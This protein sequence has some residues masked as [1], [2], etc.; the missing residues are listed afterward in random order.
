VISLR[1]FTRVPLLACP[2][3]LLAL[4]LP[5]PCFSGEE[6]FDA[7][8]FQKHIDALCKTPHRLAG[9]VEGAEARKYIQAQLEE[10]GYKVHTQRFQF[11][12]LQYGEC[13]INVAGKDYEL[14]P[15]RPN[16]LQAAVTPPAGISGKVIYA[17]DG[18]ASEF[19]GVDPRGAIVLLD[20]SQLD[21]GDRAF[22]LGAAA[23]VY[24]EDERMQAFYGSDKHV[25]ITADLPRFFMKREVAERAG[26]LTREKTSATLFASA[27]WKAVE[28]TNLIASIAG[29]GAID[30]EEE[31][32][33][34]S[35]HYDSFGS[36]WGL[37]PGA[38]SAA[39]CAALLETAR[40]LRNTQPLRTVVLAFFDNF[41]QCYLGARTFYYAVQEVRIESGNDDPLQT[42]RREYIQ[43]ERE[44][45]EGLLA[46]LRP[47]LEQKGARNLE[48]L[49]DVAIRELDNTTGWKEDRYF[50]PI[51]RLNRE[52]AK[53]KTPPAEMSAQLEKLRGEK[54]AWNR[55]HR[56]LKDRNVREDQASV[57]DDCC[58]TTEQRLA[59][60]RTE[61]EYLASLNEE[62][63][64]IGE[65]LLSG[66]AGDAER[67]PKRIVAHF[68]F[69]F[70]DLGTQWALVPSS[71][72]GNNTKAFNVF[73]AAIE[74][75]RGSR[76]W[77]NDGFM[78]VTISGLTHPGMWLQTLYADDSDVASGFGY[79]SYAMMTMGDAM[80]REGTPNDSVEKLNAS[81]V[82]KQASEAAALLKLLTDDPDFSVRSPLAAP[83]R[84]YV[85]KR[86]GA[87]FTGNNVILASE[88]SSIS[89]QPAAGAV[90]AAVPAENSS[91]SFSRVMYNP[92]FFAA[93]LQFTDSNGFFPL[94]SVIPSNWA[95]DAARFDARGRV[96]EISTLYD[97][98][99]VIFRGFANSAFKLKL[100]RC[101]GTAL[102]MCRDTLTG[103]PLK[104]ADWK[105]LNAL[106]NAEHTRYY[107]RHVD[108]TVSF[109]VP[110]GRSAKL[111]GRNYVAILNGT[112]KE[113]MGEGFNWT[114]EP[115]NADNALGGH[116][117]PLRVQT[118]LTAAQDLW[119]LNESRLQL[120]RGAGLF[121]NSIERVHGYA[122][123]QLA[124]MRE[125]IEAKKWGS[126]QAHAE[127]ANA[128]SHRV[129]AP[130]IE[131]MN[132]VIRAV[133][134]LLALTVPF[135]FS[136]E[137]LFVG[138]PNIYKQIGGFTAFFVVTFLALYF[139]H[140]AFQLAAT[141]LIIF[142]AF[143][144]IVMS[145][146]VIAIVMGKFKQEITAIQGIS[147]TVHSA[148]VSRMSTTL[149]AV[150]MGISTMRRRPLRTTLTAVTVVL[151]TFTI[152]CFASFSSTSGIIQTYQ[153]NQHNRPCLLVHNVTWSSISPG[154]VQ[155][156]E[157]LLE[158]EAAVYPR[159]WLASEPGQQIQMPLLRADGKR[160]GPREGVMLTGLIA[161]N[162]HEKKIT[163][164]IFAT[165]EG[166]LQQ[167]MDADGVFLS[168]DVLESMELKRGDKVNVG[169]RVFS[170]AG[171]FDEGKVDEIRQVDGSPFLPLDYRA[172]R[173][174]V[175]GGGMND[176][177]ALRSILQS[178]DS[179]SI[180]SI[181][182][183]QVAFMS[184]RNLR[185][186]G[187]RPRGI[188]VVPENADNAVSIARRVAQ[189][190]DNYVF[191]GLPDGV[192]RFHYTARLSFTGVGDLVVPLLLGGLI[193]FSTMLGSVVEREKEIYTFSALGLAPPDVGTLFFAEVCIYAVI[194]GLG[195]YLIGQWLVT[196]L[197]FLSL[198][199]GIVRVPDVNYSST[200]AI[201]TIL[202]VMVTVLL[203]TIYPAIKASRSANPGVQ[204]N[205][206]IPRPAGD[207]HRIIFPFTVSAYDMKGVVSFLKEHF[208]SHNDISLG[209]FSAADATIVKDP[210][211]GMLG[212]DARIWLAPF[213]L[214]I[215]Q[216]FRLTSKPSE[217]PGIHEITIEFER[218]SG[219]PANW[220]R[221]NKVF[222]NELRRQ[223]LIWRALTHDAMEMY[224]ARTEAALQSQAEGPVLVQGEKVA[225]APN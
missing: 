220:E 214:G 219:R 116:P 38:R 191:C 25:N 155:A 51:G 10:L 78:D 113:T 170:V 138:S 102:T 123:D 158:G 177:D 167:M 146:F 179:A 110:Y 162:P 112:D 194:G 201:V 129:Y 97:G 8:R 17:G 121:N 103:M 63:I 86:T 120:L 45:V 79:L 145:G 23:V 96:T 5:A 92:S 105:L 180:Q 73:R 66:K 127:A 218:L 33:V 41:S 59:R 117:Q 172:A 111:I 160:V 174:M 34:L 98:A 142:L 48:A 183:A 1:N 72:L 175:Q 205:W 210:A 151:L 159:L 82:L 139:V 203:S 3:V 216:Q 24:V 107:I 50:E 18:A 76:A 140:P 153:G 189:V 217:I 126:A 95:F 30:G 198:N 206:K 208:D 106:T 184:E 212:L 69:N 104:E 135:A 173:E 62:Y 55:L 44:H 49:S 52:V 213:D 53:L 67:K 87:S 94:V 185:E 56:A 136:L 157:G 64:G 144:I 90:V 128:A 42:V 196:G 101:Q 85:Y 114:T 109:Y 21:G 71:G 99:R 35:A 171:S 46:Q 168:R 68:G 12:Q 200:T 207:L 197:T 61:L 150:Q 222:I 32:V 181:S 182:P 166:D 147:G 193:V 156:I 187:G 26:L 118:A 89:D 221:F 134:F 223:F 165:L 40:L 16:L 178:M 115:Q 7:A 60:R 27:E 119:R 88:G 108:D 133:I 39:N 195:G 163:P 74:R 225:A 215:S 161:L 164:E 130:I 131:M 29:R 209:K 83:A 192:H 188:V 154:Q 9:T 91:F 169:G 125:K 211:T 4:L 190:T 14:L 132:D 81:N 204:R 124:S 65:L 36:I 31:A 37:A 186:V 28:G 137:R 148:E 58:K 75:L 149:A 6:A 11:P 19:N 2:A 22:A 15:M 80:A 84:H 141:P 202:I 100:F 20:Y 77:N 152:L 13:R 70:G 47:L 54:S 57:F 224:R 199:Y 93:T 176:I 143:A 122:E 43:K